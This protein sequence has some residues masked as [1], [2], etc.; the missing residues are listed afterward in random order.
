MDLRRMLELLGG[1]AHVEVVTERQ[2]LLRFARSAVTYQHSE[3]RLTARIRLVRDG[4]SAW[5]LLSSLEEDGV[6][7]LA[8]RLERLLAHLRPGDA[9]LAVPPTRA[10]EPQATTAYASTAAADSSDRAELVASAAAE[11]PGGAEL[12]GSAVDVVSDHAVAST[13]GIDRAERRTRSS[14]QLVATAGG[15]S[16][17]AKLVHRD[18]DALVAGVPD[19]LERLWKGLEPLPVV[20]VALGRHRAV[21]SPQALAGIVAPFAYSVFDGRGVAAGTSAAANEEGLAAAPVT[22]VDDGNDAAG[23]P[24]SFDSEGIGKRRTHLLAA[25]LL[26]GVVHDTASARATGGEST[27]HAVP[28]AWRFGAG[29][30][31]SHLLVEPGTATDE[32]LLAACGTGLYVQRVDYVR[33]VHPKTTLATGSSRDAT[34][35]IQDGRVV[36]RA[37]QFRF[38]VELTELL[39]AIE[40]LGARRERSELVFMESI[41]APGAVVSALPVDA[42]TGTG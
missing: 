12:G 3:E 10:A 18:R 11:L 24:T 29:P 39:R 7:A 32:E 40:L 25:G 37:P 36:G 20:P 38:T 34:L 27:G 35:W 19:A 22:L 23:L 13:A 9:V 30:S 21:L 8:G 6:R 15:R 41:V 14:L 1:D 16:S 31:A 26:A 28:P 4:R 42:L 2:E 33:V 17:Y 5:G